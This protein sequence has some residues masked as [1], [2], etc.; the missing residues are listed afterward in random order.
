MQT[1]ALLLDSNANYEPTERV[2]LLLSETQ[3]SESL[4]P[5]AVVEAVSPAL[6]NHSRTEMMATLLKVTLQKV[7]VL[8]LR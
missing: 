8:S 3:A 6:G 4:I 1:D 5:I 2:A 7:K